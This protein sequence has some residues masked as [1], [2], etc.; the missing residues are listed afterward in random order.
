M[1]L[2]RVMAEWSHLKTTH[3]LPVG[4]TV[5]VGVRRGAVVVISL[6]G[7]SAKRNGVGVVVGRASVEVTSLL[8]VGVLSRR[9]VAVV[10]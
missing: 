1:L 5:V 10:T 7:V 2:G 9:G 8:G 3:G 4:V 6:V